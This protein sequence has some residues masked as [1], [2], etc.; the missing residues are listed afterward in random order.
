MSSIASRIAKLEKELNKLKVE[1][2]KQEH[3]ESSD[4]SEKKEKKPKK[5]EDCTS[6]SQVEKFTVAELKDFIKKKK[7]DS[8]NA[9]IK[10]DFVK[11]VFKYV[12]TLNKE[13]EEVSSSSSSSGE[14]EDSSEDDEED[15]WEY[16]YY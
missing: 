2:E 10:E 12:K 15:E 9:S 4:S 3:S 8:K 13:E 14:Y 6:K 11:I 1:L 5:I 16:Y 7:L